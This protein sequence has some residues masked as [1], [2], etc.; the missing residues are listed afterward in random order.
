MLHPYHVVTFAMSIADGLAFLHSENEK[1]KISIAHRN[2][3]S[4]S[5]YIKSNGMFE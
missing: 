1:K 4:E 3:S 2:I 5:I